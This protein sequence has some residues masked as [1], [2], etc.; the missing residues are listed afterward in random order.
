MSEAIIELRVKLSVTLFLTVIFLAIGCVPPASEVDEEAMVE[1]EPVDEIKCLQMLSSAA[2][3]YKNKDWASTVRV[4]EEL[5]NVGCDKG[6]EE[7]V[8]QYWAI[9]YEYLGKFDS[10]E[11]VLL[12][13]LK[14]LPENLNLHNR[15]AYAYKRIGNKE[16]E[17]FEYE[18]ISDMT[19]DDPEPMKSLSDLYGEVGRYDD[20][21]Y[22]LKKILA[23]EPD[24][25]DAQGD[26]ARAYETTGK[27][28]IDIYRQRF[29]D[30]PEN[31]SFGLDL[32]DQ[33]MRAGEYGE[34]VKVLSRLRDSGSGNGSVSTKL[35]L[36]K[37][38]DAHYKADELE[39]ASKA[40]EK[41]FELDR[42]DFKTAL[43]V[44]QINIELMNFGKA[45]WWAEEA[46]KIAPDNGETYGHKGLVYYRAF[47]ECRAD[48]PSK[49]DKIVAR[50]AFG[51]FQTSEEKG[52]NHFKR[53]RLYLEKNSDDLMFGSADWFMLE[54]KEKKKGSVKPTGECYSWVKE[55][56][57]KD[58]SWK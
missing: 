10:S 12:Q 13:G 25:K 17:I 41:L 43:E 11:Y 28:P 58:P 20:Q 54:E 42:R 45:L 22:I 14:S 34:A 15:L 19:P 9:A 3:Y 4:Y 38:T 27:D 49:D 56:V 21:I 16:K 32:A 46:I 29:A 8:Y 50:L 6:S 24:N 31:L 23:I 35:I 30:N 53:D 2:E 48:Y 5:V 37:L 26:L 44:T 57:K 51:Y 52:H 36:N 1:R 39:E 33:L 7:E 47:Q 55:S 40:S 18:R